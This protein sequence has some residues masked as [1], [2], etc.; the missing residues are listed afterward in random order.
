MRG[1][2]IGELLLAKAL[3]LL[4]VAAV[5]RVELEVAAVNTGALE[6]YERFGFEVIDTLDTLRHRTG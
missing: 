4:E 1:K 3:R 5:E 6:L 2:G